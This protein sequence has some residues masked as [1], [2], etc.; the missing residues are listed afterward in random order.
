MD[1][2]EGVML[3]EQRAQEADGEF[4]IIVAVVPSY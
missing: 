3:V 4:L 1:L 2:F